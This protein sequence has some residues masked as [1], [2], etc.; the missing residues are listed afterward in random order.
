[1]LGYLSD[2]NNDEDGGMDE[3][4]RVGG[5]SGII[6]STMDLVQAI[7]DLIE[8]EEFIEFRGTL[9]GTG[10]GITIISIFGYVLLG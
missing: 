5:N 1:M 3:E 9:T 6:G 2:D 10:T 4:Q 8:S 7:N